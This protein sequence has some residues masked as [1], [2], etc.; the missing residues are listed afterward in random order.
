MVG[1]G[2]SGDS[3][4]GAWREASEGTQIGRGWRQCTTFR[5]VLP[6]PGLYSYQGI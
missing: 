5:R 3:P 4:C 2:L 1:L 6:A